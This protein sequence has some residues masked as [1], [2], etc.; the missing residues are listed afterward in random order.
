MQ[1]QETLEACKAGIA[2][3]QRAFN[4]QN[5]IG[6]AAQYDENAVMEARPFGT[7]QGRE[8]IQEF[9][10]GIIDQGFADV[11]YTNVAWEEAEDGGYILT[12]E[13]TMNKAFGVVHREHWVVQSD[14]HARLI[15]DDFEVQGER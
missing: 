7:F 15:S 1:K 10:Q 4:S 11:D 12:S 6:C 9:W 8:A 14:G 2:A 13:W 5:A 3:W